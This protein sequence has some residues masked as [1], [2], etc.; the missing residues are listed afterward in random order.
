MNSA[1]ILAAGKGTRL[2]EE[3]GE[4]ALAKQFIVY[5]DRP[6]WWHSAK[7][8]DN[9]SQITEI[10]LVFNEDERNF[11]KEQVENFKKEF[12]I[13]LHLAIG[14]KRRQDSVRNGLLKVSKKANFVAIHDS[15]R[16]FVSSKLIYA[17]INFLEENQSFMGVVPALDLTDTI[18]LLD[19]DKISHTLDRKSLKAVQTPQVFKKDVILQAHLDIENEEQEYTDDASILENLK[20][21]VACIEGEKSNI[22][23]TYA[24]DLELLKEDKKIDFI[25]T[26]GYDVHA[27]IDANEKK[28]RPFVLGT[29]PIN[30]K[31]CIKAH[32]DGDTLIHALIDALLSLIGAGDIGQHF[33][34]SDAQYDNISS[35]ILLD[36]VLDLLK[37]KPIELLHVDITIIA[38]EPKISPYTIQIKKAIAQLL[39]LELDMVNIKATTEEKLGFTGQVQG[40]KVVSLVS[41]KRERV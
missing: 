31:L 41:A 4:Y 36:K 8:F 18:K 39:S 15:A 19:K 6:L 32:S 30:T 40:I 28:A 20:L 37:S 29:I 35:A 23:I 27:Y 26:Y 12:S 14:G 2:K 24:K 17:C 34:D 25:S 11:A 3:Q 22:K 9:C 5:K 21:N 38:Q 33:P 1:I 16:A 7:A 10:I 13:P